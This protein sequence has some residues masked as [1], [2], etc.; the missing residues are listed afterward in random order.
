MAE[1]ADALDLGSSGISHGG[2]S[3]PFRIAGERV[4]PV[5]KYGYVEQKEE[6]LESQHH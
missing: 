2:S 3:P 5:K 1:L 4:R 6:E